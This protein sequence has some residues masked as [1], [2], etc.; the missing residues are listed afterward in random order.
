MTQQQ[1]AMNAC[2][3][4]GEAPW[5][6]SCTMC[7][8]RRTKRVCDDCAK[9]WHSRGFSQQHVLSNRAGES[10][11][12]CVWFRNSLDQPP[13]QAT[14]PNG[15]TEPQQQ[16]SNGR[17]DTHRASLSGTSLEII[18]QQIDM[19]HSGEETAERKQR[20]LLAEADEVLITQSSSGIGEIH[21]GGKGDESTADDE[22]TEEEV[23]LQAHEEKLMPLNELLAQFSSEEPR[24]VDMLAEYI[25]AAMRIQDGIAC[26]RYRMCTQQP[27]TSVVA[28]FRHNTNGD[29]PCDAECRLGL[30]IFQHM[31]TCSQPDCLFCIRVWLRKALNNIRAIEFLVIQQKKAMKQLLQDHKNGASDAQAKFNFCST[32]VKDYERKRVQ[33]IEGV[34]EMNTTVLN[35]RLPIFNFPQPVWHITNEPIIKVRVHHCC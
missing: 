3:W 4:C 35:L 11:E 34:E 21:S 22:D 5:T 7:D 20:S 27:C 9:R 10:S 32:Q 29:V 2:G 14:Q 19:E 8:P 26:T 24:L 31:K 25:N 1:L 6:Y 30:E 13:A 16:R 15:S 18:E 12:F 28:H 17:D 33:L 23:V